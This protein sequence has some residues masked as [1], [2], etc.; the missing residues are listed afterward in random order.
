M[1]AAVQ[2]SPLNRLAANLEE[3]GLE[4]MA[5]S[6]PEY[7]GLVADGRKS[8]VD[9]M[10]ELT[11]AQIAL[12]RRADDDRRTRMANFPYIKTLADFDWGFQP[13]VP[14]GPVEQLATLEFVDRG[15][16]V[17]L[18]G[19]P[20][21]GKT[22]LSIA[23]GYE[24]V[25]ARK[26]V[27]FADCSR[28]VEDL[29]HASAKGA[30]ARRMRF[31]EHC[32]LLIIDELGYLDIGKEG[33]DLLFQ[34]VNRRYALK[35]STCSY[36][37]RF[38][39]GRMAHELAQKRK[40]ESREGID[41]TPEELEA[42]R[43]IVRPLIKKGQSPEVIWA[44]RAGELPVSPSTFYRYVEMGVFGDIIGLDLPKKVRFK[45]RRRRADETPVPRHDLEGRAYKDFEAL[46]DDEK[47]D[48]VEMDCVVGRR[49]EAQAILTLL[50][51]RF[52]FQLMLFL[53]KRNQEEVGKAL[54]MVERL[55]GLREFKRLFGVVLIDRGSE[56][57]DYGAIEKSCTSRSS[58]CRVYYCDPM[59]SGQKGSCEKN[60]VELRKVIP[61]GSSFAKL[62]P[63]KLSVVCSH[64]NSYG[65]PQFGGA[66]PLQ[67]A[68][69]VVPA[70]LL[71]GL[72]IGLV[73]V[74][75]VMMK[76]GLIEL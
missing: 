42:M 71:D 24:A 8:L 76:P 13:S 62:T 70:E 51:R 4:G 63:A 45:P 56:F 29:K 74:E 73:P 9:A 69:Q 23:I 41:V 10:L 32:S 49:G 34:L 14:R 25:M 61:K 19:S 53:P 44:T 33:A 6:V 48:A 16:N 35:R 15:D 72:S 12:K 38:Y 5:S 39:D 57:L 31:Y 18:V 68:S 3:L 52:R 43:S 46:P 55:I 37:Y 47:M 26:Q 58:R 50:F 75:E 30:L 66:S 7:V 11:D 27:Y 21:V 67:L 64:V 1:S 2:A 60:H 22:H 20:G 59:K 40:V 28:L 54:D 17:V 65:R 36:E